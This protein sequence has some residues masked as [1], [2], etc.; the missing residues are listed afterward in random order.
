MT[1]PNFVIAGAARCGTTSLYYYLKQHPEIGFPDK[2][3][4]KFFSS[5]AQEFPHNGP[6]DH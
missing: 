6:G 5:K 2:K 1:L 4:P 3:E